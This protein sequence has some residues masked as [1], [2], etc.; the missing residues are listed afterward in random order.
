MVEIEMKKVIP[1]GKGLNHQ[2]LRY[3]EKFY[4]LYKKIFPQVVGELSL[5]RGGITE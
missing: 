5:S 3:A 4:A 2:N 1:N